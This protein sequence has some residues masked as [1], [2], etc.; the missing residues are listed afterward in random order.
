VCTKEIGAQ[1]IGV[2]TLSATGKVLHVVVAVVQA[3]FDNEVYWWSHR[4]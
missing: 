4:Q 2:A 3:R 1:R